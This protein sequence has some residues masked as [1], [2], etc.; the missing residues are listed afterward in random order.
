MSKL[1]T[2]ILL[3]VSTSTIVAAE[4]NQHPKVVVFNMVITKDH[5]VIAWHNFVSIDKQAASFEVTKKTGYPVCKPDKTNKCE[6]VEMAEDELAVTVTPKVKD[7]DTV[8]A[9]VSMRL[10]PSNVNVIDH[11]TLQRN[12]PFI[13]QYTPYTV[14]ITAAVELYSY[15]KSQDQ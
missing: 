9:D 7:Q 4:N 6:V 8:E 5:Q 10:E 11:V 13:K 14:K 1:L 2:F 12:V 3:A 15:S